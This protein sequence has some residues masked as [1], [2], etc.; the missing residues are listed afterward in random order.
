MLW[1]QSLRRSRR[2]HRGWRARATGRRCQPMGR[3]LGPPLVRRSRP[4]RS[5]RWVRVLELGRCP[6]L[7]TTRRRSASLPQQARPLCVPAS[8]Q[9]QLPRHGCGRLLPP[10]RGHVLPR[11]RPQVGPPP[12]PRRVYARLL[13][14]LLR[15]RVLPR[16][17]PQVGPPPRPRRVYARLLLLLLLLRG[18][19]LPRLRPQGGPPL[20][21]LDARCSAASSASARSRSAA[22]SASM[23][24][25]CAACSASRRAASSAA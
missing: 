3:G 1:N 22:C 13:L 21:R 2:S 11:L 12:R 20:Q 9:Q 19:V 10:R 15:G 16:L 4:L 8:P 24:A 25:R 17:R 5:S 6:G 14:R 7:R 18:R 23:R